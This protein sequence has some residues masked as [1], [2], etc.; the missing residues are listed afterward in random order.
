MVGPL[1]IGMG[2]SNVFIVIVGLLS[3]L[4]SRRRF[5]STTPAGWSEGIG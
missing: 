4:S 3:L 2:V 5:A 1:F